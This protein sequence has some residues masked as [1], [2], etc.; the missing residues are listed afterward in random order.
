[1]KRLVLS[2]FIFLCVTGAL[3]AENS[4]LMWGSLSNKEVFGNKGAEMLKLNRQSTILT[5]YK[6]SK[7]ILGQDK[8]T[9]YILNV[10]LPSDQALLKKLGFEKLEK[11]KLVLK[12]TR[13]N[14]FYG[15]LDRKVEYKLSTKEVSEMHDFVKSM[16][17]YEFNP[18]EKLQ[19]LSK[20]NYL[21]I[22]GCAGDDRGFKV[23]FTACITTLDIQGKELQLYLNKIITK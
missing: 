2:V 15:E 9:T 21:T 8:W 17:D 10:P 18:K 23:K 4:T 7:G 3:F 12:W 16:R 14:N 13:I 1:M 5:L 22:Y 6:W 19:E 11:M 20:K